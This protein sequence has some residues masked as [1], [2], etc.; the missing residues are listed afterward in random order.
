VDK[1]RDK[2]GKR[3][4]RAGCCH[5]RS[6][7]RRIEPKSALETAILLISAVV[8][9]LA[10]PA[11]GAAG[12]LSDF[13][14][15]EVV[16][17]TEPIYFSGDT[18]SYNSKT[19]IVTGRGHIE[20]I[21]NE[22]KLSGD[23][24]VMNLPE[25]RAEIEG[26]VAAA[27]ERE[28]VEGSKGVFD[29]EKQEGVFYTARGRSE[30]WYVSADQI[31]RQMT[32]EYYVDNGA[33]T[34]C[35]LPHPHYHLQAGSVGV[36][37]SKRIVARDLTLFAGPVP[38]FYLPYYSQGL[39]PG[40]PPIEFEAGNQSDIGTFARVG[41]NLELMKEISVTPN[42]GAFT[43]SG[44][45]AGLD[46]RVRL[47]DRDGIGRFDSF[48]IS[49]TNEE[50]TDERG[51]DKDR[52]KADIYY[53]QQITEDWTGLL[54]V[55]YL[56]DR[57][58]L[59][60]FEFDEFSEREQPET[61]LN[62]DRTGEHSVISFM[63]RERLVDFI[64]DVERRPELRLELLEQEMGN[65]GLFFSATNDAAY[66]NHEPGGPESARNF[67]DA[68]ASYPVRLWKLLSLV[69][70]AESNVTYYSDTPTDDNE[71]RLTWD[72]G[73][74]GQT[75]FQKVYG[76]PVSRYTSLRHL[77]VPTVT[78]R[79]RP[80]PNE[81]P[82]DLPQFDSIDLIDRENLL[83]FELK[84]YLHGKRENGHISEL[85]QYIL[86]ADM[87]FDDGE[88]K[89]A[90]L[91]NELL[92]RPIT[93]GELALKSLNDFRDER[94]T[95]LLSAVL[96]Y[97]VPDSFMASVGMIHEDTTLRPF[98]T[99]AVHSLSKAFG[100]LWRVG[101]EQRYDFALDDFSYQEFWVWRDLHCWEALVT[102]RDREEA[103]TVMMLLNIKA[104]PMKKI[105]SRMAIYPLGEN[106]PW[107]TRW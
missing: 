71:F 37:P 96:R 12:G 31:Q 1:R 106:A 87:E 51:V 33:L 14:D 103:T 41:Y 79:F 86:T 29:F 13:R 49:D 54:Q 82:E 15:S 28:V 63:M 11:P 60:T 32:G 93:N 44:L 6:A 81:E 8:V 95:D 85:G 67:T 70:F 19:G 2:R 34:T 66:F 91:E 75:H 73:L 35:S 72:A 65:T 62:I 4:N 17:R 46:G 50:N 68:R 42:V 94:R 83:E 39:A 59:K 48:Y 88:D 36:D 58:Y 84:N 76:S 27:R 78:Y 53:R 77:V 61:F 55:E 69:P 80:R 23:A 92:I 40:R 7:T 45:G 107:P 89:L 101:F 5:T 74:I 38:I 9:F 26:N 21:Q 104:F 18:F 43:K 3:Q 90:I 102:L 30:P 52:G 105:V 25:R 100:P 99:Q 64:Q 24:V 98:D 10:Y 56:S 57:N 22:S 16:S 97:T 47:F 20:I